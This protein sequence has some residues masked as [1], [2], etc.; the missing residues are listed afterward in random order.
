MRKQRL[1]VKVRK[2]FI[3]D[4]EAVRPDEPIVFLDAPTVFYVPTDHL[5]AVRGTAQHE[6]LKGKQLR[7][8]RKLDVRLS[9]KAP[10]IEDDCFL[11]KSGEFRGLAR[12]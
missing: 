8:R 4:E 2:H 5:L 12:F 9:A 3:G 11:R 1:P 6:P 10:P 7:S